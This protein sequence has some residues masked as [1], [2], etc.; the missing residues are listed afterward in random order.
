M[1]TSKRIDPTQQP[2]AGVDHTSHSGAS[3]ADTLDLLNELIA[4][5]DRRL[6]RI[7][8]DEEAVV[9]SAAANLR[10][11]AVRRIREIK[12]KLESRQ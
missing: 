12:G 5:L 11:E 2:P 4:A 1:N 10:S 6:P 8:P 3:M 9:A 7:H